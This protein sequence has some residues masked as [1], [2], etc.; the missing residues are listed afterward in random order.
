MHQP[1]EQRLPR[2]PPASQQERDEHGDRQARE[3]ADRRD[4]QAQAN[5][6]EVLWRKA[7][8]GRDR[9]QR[10]SSRPPERRP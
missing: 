3:R 8:Q 4:Q 5:G 9:V 1:V 7:K 2:K 10:V 6:G